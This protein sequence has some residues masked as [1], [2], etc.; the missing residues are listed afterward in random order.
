MDFNID[1]S[2]G[3]MPIGDYSFGFNDLG[4][5]RFTTASGTIGNPNTYMDNVVATPEPATMMLLGLGGLGLLR[6]RRS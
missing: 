2:T 4:S 6:K 1:G 3:T 5:F